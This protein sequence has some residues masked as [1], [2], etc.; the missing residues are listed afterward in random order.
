MYL[1]INTLKTEDMV[2]DMRKSSPHPAPTVVNCAATKQV[3]GY[4]YLVVVCDGAPS[5]EQHFAATTKKVHQWLLF[6]R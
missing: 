1:Q 6:L 4:M 5:F 3:D 2:M